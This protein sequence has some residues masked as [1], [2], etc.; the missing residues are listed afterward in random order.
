MYVRDRHICGIS[1]R[2]KRRRPVARRPVAPAFTLSL[3]PVAA[4]GPRL[5][6]QRAGPQAIFRRV[7]RL[8]QGAYVP[9]RTATPTDAA[10]VV[11]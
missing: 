2:G 9:R 1:R 3:F 8:L 11:A 10:V 4:S 6:L 5:R 7:P